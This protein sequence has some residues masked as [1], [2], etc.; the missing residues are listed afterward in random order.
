MRRRKYLLLGGG[1]FIG[2]AIAEELAPFHE[3]TIADAVPFKQTVAYL[4]GITQVDYVQVNAADRSGVLDLGTDYDYIVHAVA[5]LGINKVAQESILTINTNY[6]S[7]LYSLELASRQ[8]HLKKFLTFSTSEVYGQ[9]TVSAK[10]TDEFTIGIPE[11]ARWCYAASKVLSEHLT[12]AYHREESIPTI[13]IR[14]FN[15]YGEYRFGNN[16]ISS[17]VRKALKNED[18]LI[19]GTGEQTRVWCYINDFVSGVIHALHSEY[20]GE[21]FNLG[22][23]NEQCSIKDLAHHIVELTES[24]SRIIISHSD[25][26]DVKQRTV[27]ISKARSYL[28]YEPSVSLREGLKKYI[29]WAKKMES[30]EKMGISQ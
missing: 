1:G 25:E 11:T 28:A 27:D 15:V 3:V 19:S 24:K 2:S 21:S 22:N 14:P 30:N 16:A 6:L 12:Y 18:L 26:P 17:L 13:V 4:R 20:E 10:E 5:I 29:A 23:P 7:C 8:K 9:Y